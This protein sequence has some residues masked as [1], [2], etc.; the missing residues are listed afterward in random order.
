MSDRKFTRGRM[1]VTAY[2]ASP[3]SRGRTGFSLHQS[4]SAAACLVMTAP[5]RANIWSSI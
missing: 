1:T 2:D 4:M 3:P 5:P